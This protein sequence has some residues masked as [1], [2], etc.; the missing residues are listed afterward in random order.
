MIS[1]MSHATIYVTN[2]D[3]ALEFYRDKLGF[4][5]TTISHG[6]S[7]SLATV[8]P[9]DQSDSDRLMTQ[10]RPMFEEERQPA[11]GG[12]GRQLGTVVFNTL[13]VARR[14]KIVG[15]SL[16]VS[17]SSGGTTIRNR[18]TVRPTPVTAR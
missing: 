8:A 2:Q 6:R 11:R 17:V 4:K 9:K 12:R 14:T 10:S 15:E 7:L 13:T 1:R 18:S 3:Q 16:R 5:V